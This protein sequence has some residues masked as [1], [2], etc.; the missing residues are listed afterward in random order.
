M[1]IKNFFKEKHLLWKLEDCVPFAS[2]RERGILYTGNI[3]SLVSV[4]FLIVSFPHL[5]A[6]NRATPW[7][8][9][10]APQITWNV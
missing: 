4:A 5:T 10:D 6:L 8:L 1:S 7:V 2:G 3:L 9:T